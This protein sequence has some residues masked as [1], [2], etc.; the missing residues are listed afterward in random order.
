MAPLRA[1]AER[2]RRAEDACKNLPADKEAEREVHE[3]RRETAEGAE[4]A[5]ADDAEQRVVLPGATRGQPVP[6]RCGAFD[7]QRRRVHGRDSK[8]AAPRCRPSGLKPFPAPA[9]AASS[10]APGP[11]ASRGDAPDAKA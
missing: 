6:A 5:D 11:D 7:R 9:P 2:D 3:R 8:L 10:A 4:D 1:V